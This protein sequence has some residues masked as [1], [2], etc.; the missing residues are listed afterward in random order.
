MTR[1][2]FMAL[3]KFNTNRCNLK[4]INYLKARRLPKSS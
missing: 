4:I 3:S 1:I 2:R